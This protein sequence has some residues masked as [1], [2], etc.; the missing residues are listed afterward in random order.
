MLALL[1]GSARGDSWLAGRK[2]PGFFAAYS[3]ENLYPLQYHGEQV[4]NRQSRVSLANDRDSVG[5][6]MLNIDLRFSNKMWTVSSDV[7]R[8]GMST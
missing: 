1:P 4:P 2:I 6:P 3:R 5:M 7:M 8:Y